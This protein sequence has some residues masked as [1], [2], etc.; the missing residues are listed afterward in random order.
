MA[1]LQTLYPGNDWAATATLKKIDPTT[2]V[3]TPLTTGSVTGF[4]STS[5]TATATAANAALSVTMLHLGAGVWLATFQGSVL[6]FSLLNGLF[7]AASCYF[8]VDS[9]GNVRTYSPV[10]YSA[11]RPATVV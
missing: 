5:K 10:T 3:A 6:T 1:K 4:F 11:E 8:I 2:G 9:G 7:S